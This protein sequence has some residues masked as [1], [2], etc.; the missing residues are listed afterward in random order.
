M[1][2]YL[3]GARPY[4]LLALLCSVLY[5]PGIASI[6][7]IDRDEA[8]FAQATRQMVESGDYI[9]IRFQ[10]EPRNK[11]PVGIY[12]LQAASVKIF[13]DS[14]QSRIWPFRLPSFLG[15]L[16]AVLFTF[17][18]GKEIFDRRTAFLGSAVLAASVILIFE[19]HQATTDAA[20][21][22][23]ITAAQ[24]A[25]GVIYARSRDNTG[26][27]GIMPALVFWTAQGAAILLKGPIGPMI[28]LLTIGALAAGDRNAAWLKGLRPLWGVVLTAVIVAPWAIAITQATQGAFF[29]DAVKN[30]L[31]PKLVSG[32]ESHGAKP[33]YYL[34]LLPVTFWPGSALIAA[35]LYGAIKSRA[36]TAQRFCLAWLIPSW[37]V[38]ELVP[39]KL[40]HY[41]MPLYPALAMLTAHV[42]VTACQKADR[43]AIS[44][45]LSWVA[46]GLTA[47]VGVALAAAI[48]A[49][50]K[51]VENRF[52]PL[53][54]GISLAMLT[55]V[56][57]AVRS[58]LRGNGVK[59]LTA[60]ILGTIILF[61]VTLQF[62]LPQ[63]DRL[64]LSRSVAQIL[65]EAGV[66]DGAD[67]ASVEYQ[68]PS[69]V[70]LVGKDILFTSP[71]GAAAHLASHPAGFAVVAGKAKDA[72]LK[73]ASESGIRLRPVNTVSGFHYSKGR[74]VE[75]DIYAREASSGGGKT[76][77][78]DSP[79]PLRDATQ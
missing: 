26:P 59:A 6:P 51:L 57:A 29:H 34:L 43:S 23:T 33:G 55:T 52:D 41:I 9:R 42:A 79:T 12:W 67:V 5:L 27:V 20:L 32:H 19:A 31:L 28:S 35:T 54:I 13:G 24:W 73:A 62:I 8:R 7:P 14:P 17:G 4:L 36:E 58:H 66:R 21:L 49:V 78:S 38:F 69:L 3:Q 50:P 68:E 22:A 63:M 53:A 1:P 65:Q 39:T 15:G 77:D 60:G 10:N 47:L 2:K 72:F 74:R 75:L 70:F 25:L 44:R 64:W 16:A 37:I 40:P 71:A 18:L 30:D 11:K 56:A 46:A 48:T 45:R 61:S 76:E